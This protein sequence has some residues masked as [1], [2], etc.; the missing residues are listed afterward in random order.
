M[1]ESESRDIRLAIARWE[2]AGQFDHPRY[3][4]PTLRE[5]L[6]AFGVSTIALVAFAVFLVI[7]CIP[8]W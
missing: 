4:R 2:A 5:N 6:A 1:L 3:R 7:F 8:R